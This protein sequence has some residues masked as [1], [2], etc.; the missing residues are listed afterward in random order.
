M[1]HFCA[2]AQLLGRAPNSLVSSFVKPASAPAEPTTEEVERP[3]KR[4]RL[5]TACPAVNID[6]FA[7]L[8]RFDINLIYAGEAGH[9]RALAHASASGRTSLLPVL[10]DIDR[11]SASNE[12]FHFVIKRIDGECLVDAFAD[13][14][15]LGAIWHDLLEA[16]RLD[17]TTKHKK[18][19]APDTLRSQCL[20]MLP[21][22]RTPGHFR[23]QIKTLWRT[24]RSFAD[25]LGKEKG[26]KKEQKKE[27]ILAKY[28]PQGLPD[29]PRKWSPQDFYRCVHVPNPDEDVPS[30]IQS[31]KL[32]SQLYPFQARAVKWL[33]SREGASMTAA[34]I[35]EA[36]QQNMDVLPPSF[37]RVVDAD[38]RE[39]FVSH[40]LGILAMDRSAIAVA[41][42]LEVS[43]GILAEE[44]GLGKTVELIAL[45]CLHTRKSIYSSETFDAYSSSNVK[46][47][48]ATLI[49][50]P[51]TILQQWKNE[52]QAHAP[53][54]KV[55]H[56]EGLKTNSGTLENEGLLKKLLKQDVVLTTYNVLAT[57]IHYA[58]PTSDRTLRRA[59]KYEPRRSPL[60]QIKWWRVCLDEAQMVESGVSNA[61]TVARLVPR[62]NAW[63]V[64]G[65]PLRKDVKDLLGLLIFL[66]YE[67]YCQ[68]W[69]LWEKLLRGFQDNFRTIFGEITLR[70]TKDRVRRE[71][72]LPP[73][74]RVVITIPFSQV[75]DQNYA[76][77]FQQ[78]CDDCGLDGNGGPLSE[79]W[80]PDAST[81]IE[82]MRTW[83][84]RIRQTCL[85]PEVGGRNRRALGGGP[86]RTVGEV[87]E[88]M[89][90]QNEGETRTEERSYLVS[91]IRRGQIL[92]SA[93]QSRQALKIWLETLTESEAMVEDCRT[94][95]AEEIEQQ[96]QSAE[97]AGVGADDEV[98]K[99][100]L[101]VDGQDDKAGRVGSLRLRLRAALE[102]VHS[103]I[104]F[105]ASAYFQI[106]SN[107][108]VTKPDSEE[109]KELEKLETESYEN[110]KLIRKEMLAEVF[111]KVGRSMATI[112]RKAKAQSYTVVPEI[113]SARLKG[114]IESRKISDKLE[115][116]GQALN[117][118]ANQ[119][120]E[121]RE[122]MVQFLIQPLVDDEEGIELQGDEYET[123]TKQ[124]EEVYVYMEALRAMVADRHDA[125]TGQENVLIARDMKFA[126][127]Q[128]NEG[129]G[130]NPE[131]L[132]SLLIVRAQLKPAAEEMGSLRGIIAEVRS[133]VTSLRW[134][135]GQGSGRASAE[136]AIVE[137]ELKSIQ[138]I[139][140]D[141]AKAASALEKEVDL[142]RDAMNVRIEYY[143][144]LQKIS[145]T[146]APYEPGEGN[147]NE[148]GVAILERTEDK[149]RAKIAT[150]KAKNRYLVHLRTTQHSIA[151]VI[152]IICQQDFEIGALTVC[153]HQY[154]KECMRLWW[155]A[156]RTCPICKRHL[157][158]N[159][160]HQI[161]YKPKELLIQEEAHSP[162]H[163]A[164]T[165]Q[166]KP[167]LYSGISGSTLNQIKNIDLDGSFGTKID[168][169]A[170]HLLWIR[171]N[172]PGAKSI[173]FSQFKDFL[174]VL[175]SAF[176]HS[177][178]G[179][180]A[181]DRK[182]GIDNFKNDPS[183]ECFLLHA[184]AQSSGL[185]LVNATHVFLCEPLVNTAIE[186]QAIARV[187]R[188][189]Q[190][191]ATTVWMYLI[192]DT[193]EEAIYD[194]S[195][196]RRMAH[197]G[198]SPQIGS[199][200]VSGSAT[201]DILESS[202]DAANSLELQQAPLSTLL[203]KGTSGG[204]M[205][206]KDD[207]WSCLFGIKQKQRSKGSAELDLEVG[208]HL[209]LAAA[210]NRQEQAD[211]ASNTPQYHV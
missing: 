95:L 120:D 117:D 39:C 119:L 132:K 146:V 133:V 99:N 12:K 29:I 26:R 198:N 22:D 138:E 105:A 86:L 20:L 123:S 201:P 66:R 88:V 17:P 154:C 199:G 7:T 170:R 23:I 52:I 25:C 78:M 89:I 64:S 160:F 73:Q 122:K 24:A 191:Q 168:T 10:I 165:G 131:L 173:V 172:D 34:G 71:L 189:G 161:T 137:Q 75:E 145:D 151:D 111:R 141:Q 18:T 84:T 5:A 13:S 93:K 204:E 53:S 152:C 14:S 200:K 178:I 91:K 40:Q 72:K 202:I 16:I 167:S 81:T 97:V 118:Q 4:Q 44:M 163:D 156:H 56:Y 9:S 187:H 6:D 69:Y 32:E 42:E 180:T 82:K 195:V 62:C 49:I 3:R 164:L 85:H 100:D 59:K 79:T 101:K 115:I 184:K 149:L 83:L 128:A 106:K 92:E 210:E 177:K 125:I 181:I 190:H 65:T 153:G 129:K 58:G 48:S 174:D 38:G 102:M 147:I 182:G 1:A 171:E 43:G 130:H 175:G 90:E 142:F 63:A 192:S 51:A 203:S 186:L 104:F 67:P 28:F 36:S 76:H 50:T 179:F 134:Q 157:N 68:S 70:H 176:A 61:A 193:V 2:T 60:A 98:S 159:D 208:R 30:N 158:L 21:E 136:L 19:N 148:A 144:Q 27:A 121:W 205:V 188:I 87:L 94:K 150:L 183:V 207:L 46:N 33:L 166:D 41:R 126:L 15:T 185:N 45:I 194:I 109:Y 139:S 77:L 57:E 80:D 135:E 54:L 127:E 124:Q 162:D 31:L 47:S 108:E 211:M 209:R 155:S 113:F 114:G 35:A 55:F 11:A 197:I 140:N 116:L 37:H 143:K 74:K 107:E 8:A 110:A 112:E 103:C 169:L 206:G 96:Q 196:A